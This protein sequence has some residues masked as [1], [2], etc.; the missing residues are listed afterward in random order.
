MYKTFNCGIG[1][2]IFVSKEHIDEIKSLF[3]F[4]NIDYNI[5]GIVKN[6][7][8]GENENINFVDMLYEIE[9]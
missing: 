6:K 1:M 4:N 7:L 5:L 2:M 8:K 9:N 3:T